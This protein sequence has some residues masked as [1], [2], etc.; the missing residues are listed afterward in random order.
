MEEMG[1]RAKPVL[2]KIIQ[3]SEEDLLSRRFAADAAASLYGNSIRSYD[4]ILCLLLQDKVGEAV[5]IGDDAVIQVLGIAK[6]RKENT[7]LRS[8][9]IEVLVSIPKSPESYSSLSVVAALSSLVA[10][11]QEVPVLRVKIADELPKLARICDAAKMKL[12]RSGLDKASNSQNSSVQFAAEEAIQLI[13][14]GSGGFVDD[15]NPTL[16]IPE[17][18]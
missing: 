6:N 5:S 9:A 2:F 10:S 3:D 8:I 12:I 7:L 14:N 4:R 11:E 18:R 13:E 16:R 1:S 15:D 17:R